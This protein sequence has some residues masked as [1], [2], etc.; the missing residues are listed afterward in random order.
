MAGLGLVA[1]LGGGLGAKPVAVGIVPDGEGWALTRGGEPYVLH[2]VG[3]MSQLGLAK[4]LG[5]TTIRTWGVDQL[6]KTVEGRPLLDRVDELGLTAMVG[7]WIGHE[8]HG[9][10]Y[11]DE[12]Q[13]KRQRDEVRAAVRK[14]REHPAVLLWGLGNEMEGWGDV[15]AR[16]RI[17]RELEV[18][19]RIIKEEDPHHPVCIVVAGGEPDKVAGLLTHT[20]SVDILGVNAYGGAP[21][22]GRNLVGAGW[23]K[24][25][26]LTEFG[27]LGHWE[28][29]K[30]PWGAPIEPSSA[31]KARRYLETHR[32]VMDEGRGRCLGTFAF[33]WGQKQETTGTWYGMF[34]ESGEKLPSVDAM[35]LAWTGRQ[36]EN[37]SPEITTLESP[38]RLVRVAAGRRLRASAKIA[39]PD[40]DAWTAEWVVRAESTD[41][42]EGGDAEKAPPVVPGLIRHAEGGE[43]AFD[44]PMT[45]GAYRLFLTVRDG[46]GGASADNFPFFVE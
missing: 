19:A 20:P 45:P 29:E 15:E 41:R 7:L 38:A 33:V 12:A 25:F 14:Y 22:V 30:A 39:D 43:V 32:Q 46:R 11:R 24:P 10:D 34:L 16:T 28:V 21:H 26:L 27:P 3:G 37:R 8:R 13:L 1:G 31:D 40:G 35:A 44:A 6:E 36:P 4:K 18:L 9:F 42:K 23:T 2:G 17:W 5:A